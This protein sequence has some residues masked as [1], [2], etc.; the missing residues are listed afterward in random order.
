MNI[1]VSPHSAGELPVP[2]MKI[3]A[4]DK[5]ALSRFH[6]IVEAT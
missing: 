3:I 1:I 5:N 2:T 6:Q 4:N